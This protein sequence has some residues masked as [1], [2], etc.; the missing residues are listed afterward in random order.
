M[1]KT[2]ELHPHTPYWQ[3]RRLLAENLK[4]LQLLL[5]SREIPEEYLDRL[6]SLLTENNRQLDNYPVL[7]G[8]KAWGE[9]GRYGDEDPIACEVS[10]LIGK[11]S[12]LSPPLRIWLHDKNTAEA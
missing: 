9:S 2:T 1:A 6:N 7:A 8:K 5:L 12:A 3:K 11:S 10:P 4:A